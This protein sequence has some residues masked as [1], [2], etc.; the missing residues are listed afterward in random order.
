MASSTALSSMVPGTSASTSRDIPTTAQGMPVYGLNALRAAAMY[1]KKRKR[2]LEGAA[3]TEAA[4]SLARQSPVITNNTMPYQYG[5]ELS[6]QETIRLPK[7]AKV[8][9]APPSDEELEEGEISED[10]PDEASRI[11]EAIVIPP[12]QQ[13]IRASLPTQPVV[14]TPPSSSSSSSPLFPQSG[15]RTDVTRACKFSLGFVSFVPS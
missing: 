10:E 13:Q 4:S 3:S 8:L 9:R 7:Q 15:D 12:L 14:S 1:S 6:E 2:D 5:E 11:A